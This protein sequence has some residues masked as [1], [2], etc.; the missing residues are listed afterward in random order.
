MPIEKIATKCTWCKQLFLIFP[1]R[2]KQATNHFCGLKCYTKFNED[3]HLRKAYGI[4][5]VIKK[6]WYINQRGRCK[7]CSQPTK[8]EEL[9]VDHNHDTSEIRGLLCEWCE[10]L[11]DTQAYKCYGN[12]VTTNVV[13]EIGKRLLW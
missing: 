7:L 12:A 2:L 9:V 3:K 5:S 1:F 11:S 13:T 8:I 6:R 10:G 4:T